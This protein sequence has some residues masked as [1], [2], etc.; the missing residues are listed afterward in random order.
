MSAL[1]ALGQRDDTFI[2]DK[3]IH[4]CLWDGIKLTGAN[5]ERFNHEDMHSLNNVM[6]QCDNGSPKLIVIDG[7]YSMEGHIA[8]L[9][10]IVEVAQKHSAFIVMDDAHGFGVLGREGRGVADHYNLTDQV[11]V[12]VGSFSK[13]LAS[14]GGFIAGDR[15]VIE[16]LRSTSRQIIFS[17]GITPAASAAALASLQ[18]MQ[19]EPEHHQRL[20]ENTRYMENI[21]R[22]LGLDFWNSPTPAIPIVIGDKE[23]CFHMW[24]SL[25]EQ[26]FFTVM[27]VS[28]GV[29]VGKDLIRTAVSALHT[30]EH[31]DKFGD[32][33]KIA[34]RKAGIKTN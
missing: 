17:A 5:V 26:G 10:Q 6:D 23:K 21:L 9:P 32:A 25:W 1:T 11:D 19:S 18:V 16:Y 3:S 27:S 22:S 8:S 2:V 33:L 30:K 12:I 20:M 28:P 29:P 15:S 13:S 24:Q 4:S 34:A 7:V 31:L 14:T